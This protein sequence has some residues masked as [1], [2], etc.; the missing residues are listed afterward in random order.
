MEVQQACSN[1]I[2]SSVKSNVLRPAFYVLL[3]SLFIAGRIAFDLK[4]LS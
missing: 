4:Y 1:S 3:R 2:Q